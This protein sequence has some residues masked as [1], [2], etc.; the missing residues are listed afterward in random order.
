MRLL[1]Y[2]SICL[3]FVSSIVVN[4]QS[5]ADL[6]PVRPEAAVYVNDFSNWLTSAENNLLE[7]Q[8]RAMNDTT[9]T[10]IIVIIKPDIGDFDRSSYAIEIGNRWG[11]GQKDKDNGIVM[12]IVTAGSQRGVFISTGYG[13]EGALTDVVSARI[14]RDEMVPYFKEGRN[15]EGISRG[16]DAVSA[17]VHGEYDADSSGEGGPINPWLVIIGIFI[18]IIILMTIFGKGN[19]G[20]MLTGDGTSSGGGFWGGGFG[21]GFGGGGF[22]G[23]SSSGGGGFGGGSFGGGSFG[24]GGGGASW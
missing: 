9:S 8:L 11:V 2:I 15:Y 14:A 22:G 21:G 20:R 1:K 24:G 3:F 4:A 13:L 19:N 23:G 16:I 10:Q 12:L 17:A 5:D 18:I 6:F 7:Q